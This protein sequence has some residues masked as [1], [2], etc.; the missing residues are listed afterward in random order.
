MLLEDYFDF[1]DPRE[2]R[3]QDHRIWLHDVLFEYI[4]REKTPKELLERFPSLTL[5][6]IHA[7]LL[8]YH[9]NKE[10]MDR[11]V[12]DWL[13]YCRTSREE[14]QRTHADWLTDI[15]RRMDDQL[16]KKRTA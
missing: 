13:E 2:I 7:C 16:A 11:H 10:A 12:A 14:F 1:S 4:F 5:E 3:I 9:H 8:Y 15:R 6:K